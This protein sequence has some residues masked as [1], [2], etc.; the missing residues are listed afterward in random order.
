M[1]GEMPLQALHQEHLAEVIENIEV[2]FNMKNA[3]EQI[4]NGGQNEEI[5]DMHNI[6]ITALD[7]KNAIFESARAVIAKL[8]AS[9]TLNRTHVQFY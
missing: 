1:L 6:A 4:G 8:Y 2:N 7:F 3:L 5:E 9:S